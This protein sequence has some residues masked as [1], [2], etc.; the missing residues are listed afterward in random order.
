MQEHT[1]TQNRQPFFILT[2]PFVTA[3][4][5]IYMKLLLPDSGFWFAWQSDYTL[6]RV[7]TVQSMYCQ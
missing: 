1:E 7:Y 2:L 6:Y 5:Q 4:L 3:Q